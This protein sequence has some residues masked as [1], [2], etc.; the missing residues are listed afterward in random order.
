MKRL[1][2]WSEKMKIKYL[3]VGIVILVIGVLFLLGSNLNGN[4]VQNID[5][6]KSNFIGSI[7]KNDPS[8]RKIGISLIGY[9]VDDIISG[10]RMPL[11][12]K[13]IP[14]II[15]GFYV[16]CPSCV[17][18]IKEYNKLY[19]EY[20][21][22]ILI[23]YLNINPKD[24]KEDILNIK[25]QTNGRDWVWVEYSEKYNGLFEKLGLVGSGQTYLIKNGVVVYGDSL[26]GFMDN[27]RG[28][29]RKIL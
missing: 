12:N 7:I 4:S 9:Y 2:V 10:K 28:E 23:I 24:T 13:E 3:L 6:E 29:L 25:K 19:D 5:A 26:E 15:E 17:A 14:I 18:G 22:K 11:D 21:G 20:G 8:Y 16:G 27:L 1:V